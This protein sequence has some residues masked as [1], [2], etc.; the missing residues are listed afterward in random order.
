[1][2]SFCLLSKSFFC[3]SLPIKSFLMP[4]LLTLFIISLVSSALLDLLI[5]HI[6]YGIVINKVPIKILII[7]EKYNPE[8]ISINPAITLKYIIL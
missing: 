6:T 5:M 7:L 1:M 4:V 8:T 2:Y 3:L